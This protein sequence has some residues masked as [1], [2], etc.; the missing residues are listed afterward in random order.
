MSTVYHWDIMYRLTNTFVVIHD[1]LLIPALTECRGQQKQVSFLANSYIHLESRFSSG[2]K[3]KS[4]VSS[5][6][7]LFC[8]LHQLLKE[9]SSSSASS[10]ST[11][12]TSL[13]LTL[14]FAVWCFTGLHLS[15][16]WSFFHCRRQP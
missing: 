14:S 9:F 15:G 12:F 8:G 1:L 10:F 11:L 5:D 4:N 2:C 6:L 16:F 13:S 7:A 3:L